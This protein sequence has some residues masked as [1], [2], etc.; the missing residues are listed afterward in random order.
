MSPSSAS[1]YL[2]LGSAHQIDTRVEPRSLAPPRSVLMLCRCKEVEVESGALASPRCQGLL[3]P[4]TRTGPQPVI[5][6]TGEVNK[7]WSGGRERQPGPLQPGSLIL[8]GVY[9]SALTPVFRLH[10]VEPKQLATEWAEI[11]YSS[12]GRRSIFKMNCCSHRT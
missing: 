8:S 1:L 10:P 5:L 2:A 11:G 9:L 4:P 3:K 12:L 6:S 7:C